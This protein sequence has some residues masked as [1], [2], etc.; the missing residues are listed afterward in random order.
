MIKRETKT[1]VITL[2]AE[3]GILKVESKAVDEITLEDARYDFARAA[4]MVN[5]H[6]TPVLADSRNYT[7]FSKEVRDF[8]AGKEIADRIAA[9]AIMVSSLS[10][11]LIG[12]FFI[13]IHK[14]YFP[15][16]LFT[17]EAEAIEWLCRYREPVDKAQKNVLQK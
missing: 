3:L 13:K 10:T 4:E 15:S 12:N 16:R 9:M 11:R 1:S 7:Q 8:Y 6:K 14:P 2:D 5:Y 17:S